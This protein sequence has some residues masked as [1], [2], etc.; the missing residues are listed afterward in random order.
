MDIYLLARM[1]RS[2]PSG[3]DATKILIYAGGEHIQ[4]YR[5]FLVHLGYQVLEEE[6]NNKKRK[7]KR[8]VYRSGIFP[9]PSLPE[10]IPFLAA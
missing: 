1:L 5:E 10:K 2:Y 8:P 3:P 9:S 7:V 6:V 4:L